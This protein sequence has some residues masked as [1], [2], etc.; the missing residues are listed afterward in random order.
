M[1]KAVK[2]YKFI[3]S[4]TDNAIYYYTLDESLS[5]EEIKEK[6]EAVKVQVA[7]SNGLFLETVY[8]QEVKEE[9]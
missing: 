6:L 8:Y 2:H 1:K 3:N 9:Q 4:G 7:I 5:P